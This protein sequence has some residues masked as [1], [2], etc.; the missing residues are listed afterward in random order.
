M[1]TYVKFFTLFFLFAFP[2]LGFA[3]LNQGISV[4]LSEIE[5]ASP[6][7]VN[8]LPKFGRAPLQKD[9]GGSWKIPYPIIFVHGLTGSS[10]TWANM[11]G[12]LEPALGAA[13]PLEFCLNADGNDSTSDVDNEVES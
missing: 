5:G 4:P 9:L 12:W 1:S 6:I 8:G 11:A 13:Q 7:T 2:A 3:Q 10:E